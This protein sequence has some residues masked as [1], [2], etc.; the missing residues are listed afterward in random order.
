MT[1]MLPIRAQPVW[2]IEAR[3][4]R[5]SIVINAISRLRCRRVNEH[6]LDSLGERVSD[7]GPKELSK[8]IRLAKRMRCVLL[9]KEQA[10]KSTVAL[11]L[12]PS[13]PVHGLEGSFE[14]VFARGDTPLRVNSWR[15][16]ETQCGSI[17]CGIQ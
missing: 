1:E 15:V 13:A 4:L 9:Q 12:W 11:K 7:T 14:T 2:T 8:Q 5:C 17:I 6:M 16:F 3:D 10:N